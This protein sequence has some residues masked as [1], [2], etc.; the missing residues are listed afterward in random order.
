MPFS[1]TEGDVKQLFAR[2]DVEKC[3]RDVK[4][5]PKPDGKPSGQAIVRLQGPPGAG[6][7]WASAL[8]HRAL[9]GQWMGSR[10]VEVFPCTVDDDG[11]TRKQQLPQYR[12][13]DADIMQI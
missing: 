10:F 4:M 13:N 9:H 6:A 5:V 11:D 1:A 12:M 3:L 2:H 8:V 7:E